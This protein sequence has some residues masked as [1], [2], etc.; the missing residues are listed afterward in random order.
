MLAQKSIRTKCGGGLPLKVPLINA[1][2]INTQGTGKLYS[3]AL[4][5][6]RSALSVLR[7]Y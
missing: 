6:I 3:E 5:L 2:N 4:F 1:N 7:V